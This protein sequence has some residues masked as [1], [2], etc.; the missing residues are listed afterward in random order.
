MVPPKIQV[1]KY[2]GRTGLGATARKSNGRT[3]KKKKK[4]GENSKSNDV[5][6]TALPV[7]SPAMSNQ[8]LKKTYL[9]VHT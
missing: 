2:Y 8:A 1:S 4:E 6:S 3:K 7:E 9:G 5:K